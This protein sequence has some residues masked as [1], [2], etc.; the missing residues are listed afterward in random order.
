MVLF[1]NITQQIGVF[2]NITSR[3]GHFVHISGK[4]MGATRPD[5]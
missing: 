2:V 1:L 4:V 3:H 5:R